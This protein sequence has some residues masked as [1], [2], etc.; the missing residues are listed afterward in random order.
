[1]RF[2]NLR[3]LCKSEKFFSLKVI[4]EIKCILVGARKCTMVA[5]SCFERKSFLNLR[6][7]CE[8]GKFSSLEVV[9]ERKCA[10]VGA[11]KY[12]MVVIFHPV[13][14]LNSFCNNVSFEKIH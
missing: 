4:S 9:S 10:M 2:A 11:R 3:K 5:K 8:F 1:M 12:A 6:K 13:F 14:R 7:L